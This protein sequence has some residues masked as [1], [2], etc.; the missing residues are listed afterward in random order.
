MK[1]NEMLGWTIFMVGFL[2]AAAFALCMP[3]IDQIQRP[4]IFYLVLIAGEYFIFQGI[5][6]K[7]K[8][9][10]LPAGKPEAE[11]MNKLSLAFMITGNVLAIA[12]LIGITI[13][14]T[15]FLTWHTF[16]PGLFIAVAGAGLLG[17]PQKIEHSEDEGSS[18]KKVDPAKCIE[19]IIG[20][21][22]EIDFEKMNQK[23]IQDRI[24]D[25]QLNNLVPFAEARHEFQHD[26]G[27]VNFADFFSDFATGERSIN[28]AWSALVDG[29]MDET[30]QSLLKAFSS[31]E[32]CHEKIVKFNEE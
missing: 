29:Y 22:K 13:S 26:Y 23:A 31:F 14:K 30:R 25:I 1:L 8:S 11:K 7:K 24:E 3:P 28:R 19:T 21:I 27:L 20:I 6:E 32:M 9:S 4:V 17:M 5:Y 18:G 2:V 10:F 16:F 12:A 15:A